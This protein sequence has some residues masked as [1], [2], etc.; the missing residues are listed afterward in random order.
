MSKLLQYYHPMRK[1]HF[2]RWTHRN[3]S[4]RFRVAAQRQKNPFFANFYY[5]LV[6]FFIVLLRSQFQCH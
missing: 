2:I 1:N 5:F 4:F 3:I 6:K